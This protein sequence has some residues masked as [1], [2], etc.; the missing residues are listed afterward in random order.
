MDI[1]DGDVVSINFME[2]VSEDSD[3]IKEEAC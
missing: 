3:Q 2:K 1:D